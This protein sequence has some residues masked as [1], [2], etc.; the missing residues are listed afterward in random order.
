MNVNSLN[1][2]YEDSHIVVCIKPAGV[3]TQS[4]RVGAP[5]MV[6]LLKNH[7]Y[8]QMIKKQEPYLGVIHR[9]DQPVE[10]VL[11]FAKTPFAAKELSRE[12]TGRGFGKHYHAMVLGCPE[13][14]EATLEDYLVK[15]GRTNT[16]RICTPDTPGAKKACL[17]YHVIPVPAACSETQLS[18]SNDDEKPPVP[19]ESKT[20]SSPGISLLDITLETGRHHQI[21]V[22]L[23]HMGNPILG[24]KKYGAD[25]L[26]A[27][28]SDHNKLEL[29]AY[30]LEFHHP[31]TKKAMTFTHP[32]EK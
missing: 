29:C 26:P 15:D 2:L 3:P 17:H 19:N 28:Y 32:S 9:L 31:K 5:D 21:R 30:K 11:V 16:S 23:A 12:L 22:Q 8:Q 27:L 18:A 20:P 6:S 10:G 24:D 1:I 14:S 7:L 4:S 25:Q 13:K